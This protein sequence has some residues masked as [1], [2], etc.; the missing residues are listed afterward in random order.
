MFLEGVKK[1]KENPKLNKLIDTAS[2]NICAVHGPLRSVREENDWT[3][4]CFIK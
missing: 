3:L 4:K 2:C 1:E